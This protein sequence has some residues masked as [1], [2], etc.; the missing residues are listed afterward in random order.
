MR[1][2]GQG[3]GSDG[4]DLRDEWLE[5]AGKR[6]AGR[7]R[8]NESRD[9]ESA[10]LST[11]PDELLRLVAVQL[12]R[13]EGRVRQPRLPAVRLC[14]VC[15]VWDGAL[16]PLFHPPVLG[17][18]SSRELRLLK[19]RALDQHNLSPL[20]TFRGRRRIIKEHRL[21]L[22]GIHL[23]E[24][25]LWERHSS[26]ASALSTRLTEA[27]LSGIAQTY[28]RPVPEAGTGQIHG[29]LLRKLLYRRFLSS[30]YLGLGA[31]LSADE[32]MAHFN[33][34][35]CSA[36]R[37]FL[38]IKAVEA[39]AMALRSDELQTL[40]MDP[41]A[42]RHDPNCPSVCSNESAQALVPYRLW[43]ESS[44]PGTIAD[45]AWGVH[46]ESRASYARASRA[47]LFNSQATALP[48]RLVDNE[49]YSCE[50]IRRKAH[51]LFPFNFGVGCGNEYTWL[52]AS[53]YFGMSDVE[54][55][56][57]ADLFEVLDQEWLDDQM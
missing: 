19:M 54:T 9:N 6:G 36:Y 33:S 42:G 20:S 13:L 46:L 12:V 39:R 18:I 35:A 29:V 2:E 49:D 32:V 15:R 25:M 28:G 50:T 11:L 10:S 56:L 44:R 4:G 41:S 17:V 8:G 14:Q 22:K 3:K 43:L 26:G 47:L 45:Y 31:T 51:A 52:S 27:V 53:V 24:R 30:G 1:E 34:I 23:P 57:A 40:P 38:I 55:A 37:V 5:E 16:L 48:R 7:R 21:H